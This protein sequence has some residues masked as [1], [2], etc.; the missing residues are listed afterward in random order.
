VKRQQA[1]LDEK[2]H[3]FETQLRGLEL[4]LRSRETQIQDQQQTIQQLE[5]QVQLL[6]NGLKMKSTSSPSIKSIPNINQSTFSEV[7]L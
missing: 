3:V 4:E 7:V 2:M 6:Y 1:E 5:R